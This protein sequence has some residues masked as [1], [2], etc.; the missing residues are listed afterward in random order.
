LHL[1]TTRSQPGYRHNHCSMKAHSFAEFPLLR[2]LS[3]R[4][5]KI[6]N[7]RKWKIGLNVV[8]YR[9]WKDKMGYHADDTQ[10]E[11]CVF[12]VVLMKSSDLLSR[13]RVV[14][15]TKL[16][17]KKR[18]K[19]SSSSLSLNDHDDPND[20][21]ESTYK[22]GDEQYELNLAAGDGYEMDGK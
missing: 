16:P 17:P 12:V 5:K 4:M 9:D 1:I 18:S 13:R 2:R 14:I 19:S 7:V 6:C 8:Y 11:S 21:Q 22:H 15:R 10:K 20:L 3:H